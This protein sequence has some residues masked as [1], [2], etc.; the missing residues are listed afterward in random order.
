M[1]AEK[2]RA[3]KIREMKKTLITGSIISV[4]A[5]TGIVIG[6]TIYS[7]ITQPDVVFV[8]GIHGFPDNIDPL[9]AFTSNDIDVINQIAEG[10]F[11]IDVKSVN[12]EIIHNLAISHTWSADALNL[13]CK[14]R[15]KVIFHDGTPF[16]ASAVKWNFD[17]I[18][19][20]INYTAYPDLWLLPEGQFLINQTQVLDDYT[21]RFVLNTPFVPLESL[22]TTF[23]SYIL[24]P[25]STPED[26]F[27]NVLTEDLIGTG[28]FIY[29]SYALN[30]NVSLSSNPH[31]W[32]G[33]LKIDILIFKKIEMVI[34]THFPMRNSLLS[35]E[36]HLTKH[37]FFNESTRNEFRSDSYFT[38]Q[39]GI[40]RSTQ[41]YFI[42]NNNLINSTMRKAISYAFNYSSLIDLAAPLWEKPKSPI[43]R[44]VLYHNTTSINSP[45]YNISV[46]R[47]TLKDGNWPGTELL[48]ANDNVSAGN[49]WEKLVTDGIPFATY[50][51]S[52][53]LES[54]YTFVLFLNELTEAFKQ[55]GVKVERF[56]VTYAEWWYMV[57]DLYGY[58][59]NMF[60]LTVEGF[61]ADFN[62]PSNV[63]NAFYTNKRV[64]LN[65]GQVSD[66]Q[67]QQWMEDALA[68]IDP[69][70][71]RRLYY[72]IQKRLIEEVYPYLWFISWTRTDV[73]VSNLRGW[74][75]NG[76][77]DLFKFVYFV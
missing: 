39:E 58:H 65:Y 52:F 53:V 59:R 29:D 69:I 34:P 18:Q 56:N 15:Q 62:D 4:L 44:C 13:T 66:T 10:L 11:E 72:D 21:I 3:S 38:L 24:S 68:E 42:L 26:D 16:N 23:T 37:T 31:Y 14:L 6:I 12:S 50:N 74:Y 77:K 36:I 32:G 22:L 57:N 67:V 5:I 48:T 54:A 8:V 45:Y 75:P 43:P 35:R 7:D 40:P 46:A 70:A 51:Y 19:R 76:F 49:E 1:T 71:R 63:I 28:P 17:R 27:L 20:H 2:K 47:Q 9:A 30:D 61:L 41:H 25:T 64:G 60:H 73:H 33:K 55:I